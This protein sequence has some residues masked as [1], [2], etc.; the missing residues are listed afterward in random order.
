MKCLLSLIIALTIY[1]PSVSYAVPYDC[2]KL[3]TM[4]VT[5]PNVNAD[6]V[7]INGV[8]TTA[9]GP[10]FE[11]FQCSGIVDVACEDMAD[12]TVSLIPFSNPYQ[13]T[14]FSMIVSF[15]IGSLTAVAFVVAVDTASK[16]GQA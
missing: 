5:H 9:T 3:S 10:F 4:I 12:Y 11:S 6:H 7:I 13:V 8:V 16:G 15:L 14:D 2:G 1:F